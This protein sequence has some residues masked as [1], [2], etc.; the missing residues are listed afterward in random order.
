MPSKIQDRQKLGE[1][2]K[3][4]SFSCRR[5]VPGL[6]LQG[7]QEQKLYEP[8]AILFSSTYGRSC[9]LVV[10]PRDYSVKVNIE[11]FFCNQHLQKAS[12]EC[13]EGPMVTRSWLLGM[14]LHDILFGPPFTPHARLSI[15]GKDEGKNRIYNHQNGP[16]PMMLSKLSWSQRK[17][18]NSSKTGRMVY[19]GWSTRSIRKYSSC[20]QIS[21]SMTLT[22]ADLYCTTL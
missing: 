12:K 14:L 18:L 2:E 1:E 3:K 15:L 7:D 16:V 17:S 19:L 9:Y 4:R 13:M 8:N 22:H 5:N 21:T 20:S 10:K 6:G 11:Y